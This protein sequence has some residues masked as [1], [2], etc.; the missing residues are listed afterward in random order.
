[1][2]NVYIT[3]ANENSFYILNTHN[4]LIT[5]RLAYR[6]YVVATILNRVSGDKVRVRSVPFVIKFEETIG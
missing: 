2:Y 6:L 4:W 3:A 5:T 1:V